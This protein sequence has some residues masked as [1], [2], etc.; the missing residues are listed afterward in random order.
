MQIYFEEVD[1]IV[2]FNDRGFINF[3]HILEYNLN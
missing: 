1:K 2:F 3:M